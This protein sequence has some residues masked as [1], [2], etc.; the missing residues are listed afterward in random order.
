VQTIPIPQPDTTRHVEVTTTQDGVRGEIGAEGT[1]AQGRWSVAAFGEWLKRK[2]WTVGG[3]G[4]W[5]W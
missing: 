1:T 4:R 2:G 3:T 5:T